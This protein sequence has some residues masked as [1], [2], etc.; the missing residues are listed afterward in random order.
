LQLSIFKFSSAHIVA[1][2]VFIQALLLCENTNGQKSNNM[3]TKDN[4]ILFNIE[5][6]KQVILGQD[7]RFEI[8]LLA[9]KKVDVSD[10]NTSCIEYLLERM[11]ENEE[12]R[13]IYGYYLADNTQIISKAMSNGKHLFMRV[14]KRS[15]RVKLQKGKK[16]EHSL[17]ISEIFKRYLEPGE[18]V[19][20]AKYEN[21]LNA[22]AH[23][24]VKVD[25]KKSI[26]MLINLI[27]KGNY[28]TKVW[29]RNA[30]FIMTGRPEWSPK[31]DDN[32]K[33]VKME[34]DRLRV[35][36]IENESSVELKTR[37]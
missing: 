26:P 33:T 10:L 1:V 13:S 37:F 19:L 24:E 3:Q 28:G 8:T 21:R 11:S 20:S 15:K 29:A 5:L 34:C 16:L 9:L 2:V 31:I 6:P 17:S 30:I 22:E 14:K 36:W 23:F 4:D 35:W 25:P 32:E 12:K 18:Y 27:E 7:V